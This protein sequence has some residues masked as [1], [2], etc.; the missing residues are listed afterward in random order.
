MSYRDGYS[1]ATKITELLDQQAA[2]YGDEICL[3][4]PE[5]SVSYSYREYNSMTNQIAN[6][7]CE[8]GVKLEERVS[9]LMGNSPHYNFT[10]HGINKAGAT[11]VLIN[12]GLHEKE[13]SFIVGNS[14]SRLVVTDKE[15]ENMLS[16]AKR[17][18]GKLEKIVIED[19]NL[20]KNRNENIKYPLKIHE[21]NGALI[22][23]TS[24]TTGVPKGALLSNLN[25]TYNAECMAMYNKLHKKVGL[26]IQPPFYTDGQILMM[27]STLSSGGT[28]VQPKGFDV[29]NFWNIVE[30][31]RIQFA[32]VMPT[33]LSFLLYEGPEGVREDISSIEFMLCSA[34]PLS[35]D[36]QKKFEERFGIPIV[37]GYGLTEAGSY[38]TFNLPTPKNELKPGQ[39]DNY[40][41][42]GSVGKAVGNKIKIVDTETDKEVGIDKVGEILIRGKNV[43]KG[44][45]NNPTA[46]AETIKN[47]WL[48]TG[49]LGTVDF[50]G[51]YF[52]KGRKKD[53]VIYGGQKIFAREVEDV[54]YGHPKVKQVAIIPVPDKLWGEVPK[55]I[56]TLKKGKFSVP[57]EILGHCKNYLAE[58]KCPKYIQFVESMP[59]SSS[60]KILK[61][62]LLQEYGAN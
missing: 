11:A 24:G 21:G 25:A 44:Y 54:I 55:A 9:I 52:I 60:G 49:D 62:K 4:S 27:L 3:I 56:I 14:G 16:L 30:K 29:K 36:L 23:Y 51:Y 1:S 32:A 39:S 41:K 53:M 20:S 18:N 5:N 43:M 47:G 59:Q 22:L 45:I 15:H 42:I 61:S 46:T 12:T 37:E 35:P 6:L 19:L 31:H 48:Y 17:E 13:I 33:N 40:R 58:W 38:S 2:L 57:E 10:T 26:N 8:S 28:I 7:L 50:D 34:A